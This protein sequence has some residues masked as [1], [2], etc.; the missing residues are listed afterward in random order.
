MAEL[1][2][3]AHAPLGSA[4]PSRKSMQYWLQIPLHSGS[5]HLRHHLLAIMIANRIKLN[6]DCRPIVGPHFV[7]A[8]TA[9]TGPH[10]RGIGK[11]WHRL[12]SRR[13]IR[14]DGTGDDIEQCGIRLGHAERRF[15]SNHRRPD[16]QRTW[17]RVRHPVAVDGYQFLQTLEKF[18]AAEY[19][20]CSALS[21]P[22]HSAAVQQSHTRKSMLI[23]QKELRYNKCRLN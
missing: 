19:R 3:G 8:T 6:V 20:Q 13:I 1:L 16:V 21:R 9:D 23:T 12:E 4:G 5:K 15:C 18:G 2:A 17:R 22:K 10:V 7:R 14:S 11:K